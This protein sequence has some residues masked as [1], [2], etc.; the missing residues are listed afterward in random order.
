[1]KLIP[2]KTFLL[3][4]ENLDGGKVKDVIAHKGQP[5][6]VNEKEAAKFFGYFFEGDA[7]ESNEKEKKKVVQ[8]AKNQKHTR[9]V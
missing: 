2:R 9:T 8:A 4:Q 1:M 3:R 5:I 6:E 7:P